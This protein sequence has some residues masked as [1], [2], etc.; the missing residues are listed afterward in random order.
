[1]DRSAIPSTPS[2]PFCSARYQQAS[3]PLVLRLTTYACKSKL[4]FNSCRCAY[5]AK[6]SST[7]TPATHIPTPTSDAGI[8]GKAVCACGACL[9]ACHDHPGAAVHP[10][11]CSAVF[12]QAN[13][14]GNWT[15]SDSG[16]HDSFLHQVTGAIWYSMSH[17][18]RHCIPEYQSHCALLL[19][20]YCQ[21][22]NALVSG[23]FDTKF[24]DMLPFST[25]RHSDLC[26]LPSVLSRENLITHHPCIVMTDSSVSV[27]SQSSFHICVYTNLVA[28]NQLLPSL[29]RS[30]A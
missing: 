2:L 25:H 7:Q 9:A 23:D 11:L 24:A 15:D 12:C 21:Q 26:I 22:S 30:H 19:M 10:N 28:A 1:M 20:L 17:K 8:W 13:T 27:A 5:A 29:C 6:Q 4:A 14:P 3:A 16:C 18:H